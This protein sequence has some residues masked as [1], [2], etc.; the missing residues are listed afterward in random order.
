VSRRLRLLLGG[1]AAIV[2]VT[3]LVAPVVLRGS[4]SPRCSKSLA[5]GGRTYTARPADPRQL[6]QALA[7]GVGVVRGCG[8]QPANVDVRSLVGVQSVVAVGVDGEGDSVF[9]RSGLCAAVA[10]RSLASCLR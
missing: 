2:I 1:L 6:V 4:S 7:I 3:V 5:Y 9:V 8:A 10:A